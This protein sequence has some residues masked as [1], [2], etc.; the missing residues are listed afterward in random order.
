MSV[1]LTLVLR[2][3]PTDLPPPEELEEAYNAEVIEYEVEEV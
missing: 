2:L 3:D 1:E